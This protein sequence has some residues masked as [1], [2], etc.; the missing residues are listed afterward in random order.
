MADQETTFRLKFENDDM[1]RVFDELLAK[2][3]DQERALE[4]LSDSQKRF[5]N[6]A[7][8]RGKEA[9]DQTRK[10][11]EQ[12]DVN[13]V[14]FDNLK[15]AANEAFDEIAGGAGQAAGLLRSLARVAGPVGIALA[16]I[17][18]AVAA[19]F[20]DVKKNA[21]EAQV[22][23]AG[24][25]SVA[26]ELKK[27]TFAGIRAI[28]KRFTGDIAGAALETNKAINGVNGTLGEANKRGQ[29][30]KRTQL[31]LASSARALSKESA[32]RVIQLEKLRTLAADESKTSAERIQLIRQAANLETQNNDARAEQI[33]KTISLRKAE[34][35]EW[36]FQPEVLDEI[37]DLETQLIELR[38]ANQLI[39]IQ[40]QQEINALLGEEAQARE[41]VVLAARD[42]NAAFQGRENERSLEKQIEVFKEL[43]KSIVDAGLEKEFSKEIEDLNSVIE[44]LS[45]RLAEGIIEPFEKLPSTIAGTV[46]SQSDEYVSVGEVIAD[47]VEKSGLFKRISD[48][49]LKAISELTPEQSDFFQNQLFDAANSIGDIFS[50]GAQLAITR[51]EQLVEA[52]QNTISELERQ[53]AEEQ[54]L[55]EQGFANDI[56]AIQQRLADEGELLRAEQEKRIRLE[57]KAANQRLVID[58]LQQAS[59]TTLAVT[60]LLA[61]GAS[62]GL[63]GLVI[64]S[65]AI[66]LL[67][68]LIAKGKADAL[69]SAAPPKFREG[70]AE[71]IGPSHEGGGILI[72]AE[73]GERILSAMENKEIG[74]RKLSNKGLVRYI[75][76]GREIEEMTGHNA[77]DLLSPIASGLSV[78]AN[79]HQAQRS[80][81]MAETYAQLAAIFEKEMKAM[82]EHLTAEMDRR[83]VDTPLDSP[84][85]REWK[86]G[87][88]KFKEII[89]PK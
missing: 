6:D 3:E 62:K 29:E 76:I 77:N 81:H 50:S 67:F 63:V 30:L 32:K 27:R 39:S 8:K 25:K 24:I 71:L 15:D 83:P 41:R 1:K 52:R 49:F 37:T 89:K 44:A 10:Q 12:L 46:S 88:S 42:F 21:Q 23:L 64:A 60:R 5:F 38:G 74:G 73:G 47:Q 11:A 54:R 61:D 70:T 84:I 55:Q 34:N 86:E 43:R 80:A 66:A 78:A 65:A 87:G 57:K 17:G 59:Q 58:G 85:V 53:L 14:K 82:R 40:T 18:A 19:A 79:V 4:D 35:K 48:K 72:E 75:K 45:K 9:N 33:S 69:A 36:E 31:Q 26:E 16:G 22:Q 2:V 68:R 7:A 56:S 51:Q 20:L 13:K 28:V